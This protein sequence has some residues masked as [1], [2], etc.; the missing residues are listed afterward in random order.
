MSSDLV[1]QDHRHLSEGR[2]KAR[3]TR[4]GVVACVILSRMGKTDAPKTNF[5]R[6]AAIY[7]VV[8]LLCL[9][10]YVILDVMHGGPPWN[11]RW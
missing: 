10:V 9:L 2:R 3:R 1:R 5:P 8:L 11:G 4:I 6:W 7:T